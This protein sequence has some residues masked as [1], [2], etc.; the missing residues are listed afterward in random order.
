MGFSGWKSHNG[1]SH[2]EVLRFLNGADS[3][4]NLVETERK[5]TPDDL[6]SFYLYVAR[7]EDATQKREFRKKADAIARIENQA[8]LV[9]LAKDAIREFDDFL[10]QVY[11]YFKQRDIRGEGQG[12]GASDSSEDGSPHHLLQADALVDEVSRAELGY[13]IH[14]DC[15]HNGALNAQDNRQLS[16]ILNP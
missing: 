1:V 15:G 14:I 7:V 2:M 6:A 12:L 10:T 8:W 4:Q 13:A 11:R 9:L 16:F 3:I 5:L